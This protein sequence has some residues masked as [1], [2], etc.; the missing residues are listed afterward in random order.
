MSTTVK[1][2]V[3]YDPDKAKT[4]HDAINKTL[5]QLQE[6][7][8]IDVYEIIGYAAYSIGQHIEQLGFNYDPSTPYEPLAVGYITAAQHRARAQKAS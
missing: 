8:E 6:H 1:K 4:V 3:E 7:N 5:I 2:T